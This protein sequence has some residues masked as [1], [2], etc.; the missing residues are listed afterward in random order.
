MTTRE[1]PLEPSAEEM[2]AMLDGAAERIVEPVPPNKVFGDWLPDDLW[3]MRWTHY[4]S[5]ARARAEWATRLAVARRIAGWLDISTPTRDNVAAAEA[6]MIVD[7]IGT[8]DP[9]EKVQLAIKE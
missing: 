5:L 3:S 6:V 2:R 9:W 4:G 1:H 8:T 7:V